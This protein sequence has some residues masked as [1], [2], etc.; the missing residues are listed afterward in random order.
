M[1][2]RKWNLQRLC[3]FLMAAV[4]ML[5]AYRASAAGVG[6][7]TATDGSNFLSQSTD[8]IT[9]LTAPGAEVVIE[10]LASPAGN[11]ATVRVRSAAE[12]SNVVYANQLKATDSVGL[13]SGLVRKGLRRIR[14]LWW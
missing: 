1:R 10:G 4:L 14:M 13:P 8:G 6:I 2:K 12:P 11:E 7:L 3:I 9:A 5:P